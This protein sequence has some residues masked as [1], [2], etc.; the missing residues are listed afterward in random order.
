ME[1]YNLNDIIQIAGSVVDTS[2]LL[3]S[4]DIGVLSSIFEGLPLSLLEY[5]L[6]GLPVVVTDVGQ[7]A[8]R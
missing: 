3:A 2:S 5:G 6:A 1:E 4:A 8:R 7:S